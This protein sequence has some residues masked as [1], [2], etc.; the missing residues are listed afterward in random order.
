[1]VDRQ[2][3]FSIWAISSELIP[4]CHFYAHHREVDC[5]LFGVSNGWFTNLYDRD[6]ENPLDP[7][8][9]IPQRDLVARYPELYALIGF[10]QVTFGLKRRLLKRV[11]QVLGAD[12]DLSRGEEFVRAV[13]SAAASV[14]PRVLENFRKAAAGIKA[15]NEQMF[16]DY[17]NNV[18]TWDAID[19]VLQAGLSI[20]DLAKA[21]DRLA[22][23]VAQYP[24][25]NHFLFFH[26]L[27]VK[28]PRPVT[29][30]YY[31][32]SL[33]L[34]G[35]L[36][37]RPALANVS[38]T[39]GPTPT[40]IAKIYAEYVELLVFHLMA[41]PELRLMWALEAVSR[42]LCK[43]LLIGVDATRNAIQGNVELQRFINSEERN[44]FLGPSPARTLLQLVE[45]TTLAAVGRFFATHYDQSRHTFRFAAALAEYRALE[46][47]VVSLETATED[48]YAKMKNSLGDKWGE[49]TFID[50]QNRSFDRLGHGICEVISFYPA[51]L[52]ALSE[53]TWARIEFLTSLGN[54]FAKT[55]LQRAD[56]PEPPPH[57]DAAAELKKIFDPA[58][59]DQT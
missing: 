53:R 8:L 30:D 28:D 22:E 2:P 31:F 14:R 23:R 1:M 46:R 52:P 35:N 37:M 48:A 21:S 27:L 5:P 56:R 45:E 11:E 15:E 49:L 26:K 55:C 41:R 57:P 4:S 40:P 12:V 33:H 25:G 34:L 17:L 59:H 10:D 6:S 9:S 44:A 19:T 58:Q 13:A 36:A 16:I 38:Y 54:T 20:G 43:R 50:S 29:T 7:I 3:L 18:R 42:R 47:V 32:N 51:L 24:G 39:G